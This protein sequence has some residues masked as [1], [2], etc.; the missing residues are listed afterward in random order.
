MTSAPFANALDKLIA[1]I[2]LEAEKQFAENQS[3]TVPQG[4]ICQDELIATALRDG[5]ALGI[6]NVFGGVRCA[7]VAFKIIEE[8]NTRPDVLVARQPEVFPSP[9]QVRSKG[10]LDLAA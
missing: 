7:H 6:M 1:S 9:A 3:M 8:V 10:R 4:A 5:V 2:R